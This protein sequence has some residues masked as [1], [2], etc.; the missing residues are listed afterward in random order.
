MHELTYQ[1]KILTEHCDPKKDLRLSSLLRLVQEASIRSVEELGYPRE[2]TLDRGILWVVGKQRFEISRLPV[3]DEE[4]QV[5]TY[6]GK[7][8]HLFFERHTFLSDKQGNPL[9]KCN[10]IWAL[11]DM[12]KRSIVNPSAY[13]ID[14][15]E[16]HFEGELPFPAGF[17]MEKEGEGATIEAKWSVCDLNGH[18]NNAAYLDIVEDLIPIEFLKSHRCKA[19]DIS[20]KKEIPLGEKVA[21]RY[22]YDAPFYYFESDHF[23]LRLEYE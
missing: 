4:I 17:R 23:S 2:K 3:Y 18:L 6:P 7:K 11:I 14:I 20:Y 22:V 1:E 13:G 10:A 21:I 16:D 9:V 8:M 19:I 12:N 15:P 5:L